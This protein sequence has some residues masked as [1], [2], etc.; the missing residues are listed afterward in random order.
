MIEVKNLSKKY[1]KRIALDDVSFKLQNG[2]IYG[3]IGAEGAGK[4]T[5][6]RLLAG[7]I[8]PDGGVVK[9]NGFDMAKETVAAKSCIGYLAEGAP[10]YGNMTPVEYLSY[11]AEVRGF[12]YE[13]GVRRVNAALERARLEN[14]RNCLINRLPHG[15]DR[16][17]AVV[18]AALGKQDI[19]LLDDPFGD[20]DEHHRNEIRELIGGLAEGRT[21]ILSTTDTEQASHCDRILWLQNG[22][23]YQDLWSEDFD[24]AARAEF[25]AMRKQGTVDAPEKKKAPSRREGEYEILDEEEGGD[26]S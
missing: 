6:L 24:R 2:R 7:V 10:L 4:S 14:F 9:I 16:R 12:S 3:I 18:Q 1:Q 8:K 19:L 23:L 15:A 25:R 26:A 17:L 21:V 11:L 20:M 13:Q 22:K 5:L